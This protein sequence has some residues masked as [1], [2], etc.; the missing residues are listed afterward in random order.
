MEK[1]LDAKQ[2]HLPIDGMNITPEQAAT[3]AKIEKEQSELSERMKQKEHTQESLE[4]YRA[5]AQ[6]VCMLGQITRNRTTQQLGKLAT[7]G[8]FA[9]QSYTGFQ[10]VFAAQ[11]AAS[12]AAI[13][14]AIANGATATAA[15]AAGA[16]AASGAVSF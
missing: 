7:A 16:T 13:S 2:K 3:L 10:A 11:A 4:G 9:Y 8:V 5:G 15:A 6:F 1:A 12:A 14:T